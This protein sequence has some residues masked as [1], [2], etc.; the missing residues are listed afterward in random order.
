MKM[1]AVSASPSGLRS[2]T[3][4]TVNA[5]QIVTGDTISAGIAKSSRHSN[6][7][8]NFA[9][10][11][12]NAIKSLPTTSWPRVSNM[13]FAMASSLRSGYQYSTEYHMRP[14]A[15]DIRKRPANKNGAM[16]V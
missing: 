2:L 11:S 3:R 5:M 4:T 7:M 16:D 8:F 12:L 6:Q 13:H 14:A 15:V 10:A 9:K 1:A